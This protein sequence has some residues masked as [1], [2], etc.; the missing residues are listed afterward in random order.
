MIEKS[1]P[2][3]D[4][5]ILENGLKVG[6]PPYCPHLNPIKVFW[7][8]LK[9]FLL[10]RPLYSLVA[11]LRQ[12]VLEYWVYSVPFKSTHAREVLRLRTHNQKITVAAMQIALKKV[13]AQR[14]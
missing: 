8:R 6:V 3:R 2:R 10:P 11:D 1:P 13:W 9:A 12:A 7:Q 4:N 14:S 5:F